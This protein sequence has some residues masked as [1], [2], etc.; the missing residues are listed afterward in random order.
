MDNNNTQ[1]ECEKYFKVLIKPIITDKTTKLLEDNKYTFI[2]SKKANKLD[3][4][5][6]ISHIYNVKVLSV[7]TVNVKR[8]I[9]R[10]GKYTGFKSA[11]KK[12]I[13]A[14]NKESKINFF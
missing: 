6:A 7:T 11:F 3:I 13:I 12:A 14:L 5:K 9:K 4:K 2:V 8:K 10:V 1:V